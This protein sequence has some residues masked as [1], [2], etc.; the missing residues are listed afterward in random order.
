[1]TTI[2]IG[3][4]VA[5][6]REILQS[7]RIDDAIAYCKSGLEH[8]SSPELY[9]L[10]GVAFISKL[11]FDQAL[12]NLTLAV[13][14]DN[15]SRLYLECICRILELLPLSDEITAYMRRLCAIYS[16]NPGFLKLIER[17]ALF[18]QDCGAIAPDERVKWSAEK[19]HNIGRLHGTDKSEATDVHTYAGMS[20][21]DVYEP[22][23]TPLRAKAINFLEIG[24]LGGCSLRAWRE[25]FPFGKIY[26][27]DIDPAAQRHQA[28]RIDI[29][30]GSQADPAVL[31]KVMSKVD[32]FDV[33][34][35][36]G[37]HA[38]EHMQVSFQHL[39]TK[40]KPGGLYIIEDLGST[41]RGVDMDW[42]GMRYNPESSLPC[43]RK[44][45]EAFFLQMISDL[46]H[47]RGEVLSVHFWHF[48]MIVMK[49]RSSGLG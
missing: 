35:D 31:A 43:S 49:K 2:N 1:M 22:Y 26:G 10:L 18:M 19:L 27:L 9:H 25:F 12:E 39:W 40:L 37:S 8:E 16:D 48:L 41:Y 14:L 42:P 36:D 20:Y 33:I 45:F 34:L 46:D 7:G 15:K 24:V 44:E 3:N 29:T 5:A 28:D 13:Q 21:M 17:T 47:E 32:G 4:Y 6:G 23:L 30:I 38:S 11:D